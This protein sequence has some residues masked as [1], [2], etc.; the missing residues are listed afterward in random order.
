MNTERLLL[1]ATKLRENAANPV[2]AKFD[3]RDWYGSFDKNKPI[4]CG[5]TACAMGLAALLPEFQAMGLKYE[6]VENTNNEIVPIAVSFAGHEG[7]SA[8]ESLFDISYSL[9]DSLFT[10]R[11]YPS[12][13]RR[14]AEGELEV[15]E[16]LEYL[17][18]NDEE[19][20]L[21]KYADYHLD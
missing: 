21:K 3:I 10:P 6:T 20:F 7:L 9:A 18:A 12:G 14:G 16:R 1:L 5:T 4:S 13:K 19:A 15:A 17:A 11:D 8:A 2:G